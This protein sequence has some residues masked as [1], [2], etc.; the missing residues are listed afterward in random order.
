MGGPQGL[1]PVH[2][3][4]WLARPKSVPFAEAYPDTFVSPEFL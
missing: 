4:V 1:K 3:W 2:Y